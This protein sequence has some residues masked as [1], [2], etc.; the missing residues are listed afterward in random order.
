MES[1]R[2]ISFIEENN[3]IA[4][5]VYLLEQRIADGATDLLTVVRLLFVYWYM[6]CERSYLAE[7]NAMKDWQ[8]SFFKLYSSHASKLA[9]DP[10][11]SWVTG[12]LLCQFPSSDYNE[13][14]LRLLTQA[15]FTSPN[16]Q[17]PL[18]AL[19][20]VKKEQT[21]LL[22]SSGWDERFRDWGMMGEYF[23]YL[24]SLKHNVVQ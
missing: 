5:A 16:D 11:T 13:H 6:S 10:E 8:H 19:R 9:E 2:F 15:V 24:F 17:L 3:G 18:L 4:E 7:I 12:Y 1:L 14:G 22:D 20:I 21:L 23:R